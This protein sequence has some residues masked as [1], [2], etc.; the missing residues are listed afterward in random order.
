MRTGLLRRRAQLQQRR[1][2]TDAEGSP[3]EDWTT[4]RRI[5][6]SIQPLAGAPTLTGGQQAVTI[7][8]Q[9]TTR[10]RP[11]LAAVTGHDLRLVEG[12]RVL[13]VRAV[14]DEDERHRKLFLNCE[15]HQNQ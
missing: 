2:S 3:Q 6:C 12:S 7:T 1:S 8:H 10:Y 15:E 14:L 13:D 11:D 4:I 9:V 5:W